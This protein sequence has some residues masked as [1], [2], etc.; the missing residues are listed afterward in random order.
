MSLN[1]AHRIE[2]HAHN[3]EKAGAAKK[4][5]SDRRDV[6]SLAKQTGQNCDQ[7]KKNRTCKSQAGHR[8]IEEIRRLFAG[9]HSW[10]VPAVFFQIIRD[11]GGLELG[12]DPEITEKEN[13]RRE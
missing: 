6:Q 9:T 8:E 2:N 13:H 1:L 12:G 4:L 3:N 11:L 7:G 5:R 10:D